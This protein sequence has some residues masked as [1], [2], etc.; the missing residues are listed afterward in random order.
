[1]ITSRGYQ[2]VD[3]FSYNGIINHGSR[4]NYDRITATV[5]VTENFRVDGF[6]FIKRNP[7]LTIRVILD[8]SSIEK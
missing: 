6:F 5:T 2:R 8:R 3:P 7:V 4:D 1:M